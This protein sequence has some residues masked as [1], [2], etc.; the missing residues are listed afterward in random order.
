MMNWKRTF[1]I[2]WSGQFF[3][4]LTSSI[5]GYAIILWI[6]LETQSA[7]VL[8]FG[9]AAALLPQ[10]VLGL[11]TGVYI[12]RWNRKLVM[13]VSDMFMAG[14]TALL[15]VMF[16]LGKVEV[17][18]I[19]LLSAMRSVGNAFYTPAMQASVPLLAPKS[20]LM[21]ISGI[22]QVIYSIS[23][24]A[25]PAIA[26]FLIT[27]L[28]MTFI[29]ST[30]VV[31]AFVA[32]VSLLLVKIP[33]PP[34]TE[35]ASP[36]IIDEI[37]TGL[38][39]IFKPKGMKWLFASDLGAMFF[40]LPISALFPLMTLQHF[41]GSTYQMSIIEIVWSVGMLAGGALISTNKLKMFNKVGIIAIMCIVDGLVFLFSGLLPS[42]GYIYFAVFS[43]IS[44]VAA[45]MWNSA[46]TVI[47]QT[48]I[49]LDKQGRAF[50]TYDSLSL[51][52]SIPGLLATGFIA[53]SIGL[54]NSFIIAGA[55]ILIIGIA[56][57]AI[58][59]VMQLG[60]EKQL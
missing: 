24:I 34:K 6:S 2:I 20:E 18:H 8:A 59:S 51:L 32:C 14:C 33:N 55:G 47:M 4:A 45:A 7:E 25:G 1:A 21:R 9:M 49:D 54:T 23:N 3:S 58:P 12:D 57:L 17:W 42:D 29:L 52:P 26:A 13:I 37:K 38:Q 46:F 60:N 28:D 48:T 5:V 16:Y 11:F 53:E 15:C 40:I 10:I 39:A 19:Y 41:G 44:G 30:E 43:A 27:V 31:G 36:H 56:I 35:N 22:N 50:S